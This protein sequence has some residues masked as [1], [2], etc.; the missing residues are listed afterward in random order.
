MSL[1]VVLNTKNASQTLA[2]TLKSIEKIADE[3]IVVDM[4]SDDDTVAIAKKFGAD[5]IPYKKNPGYVE[6]ARN[7]AV[8]KAKSDWILVLDAD[9]VVPQLLADEIKDLTQHES[10]VNCYYVARKNLIFGQWFQHT[11]WWPDYQPRL[12]R[13]GKVTWSTT[14]HRLPGVVG[15]VKHLPAD[16]DWALSHNNYPTVEGFL[17]RLNRYTSVTARE[18]LKQEPVPPP[19]TSL[20]AFWQEFLSRCFAHEGLADTHRGVSLSLLQAMYEAV[21]VLKQAELDEFAHFNQTEHELLMELEKWPGQLHYW[22]A[23]WHVHHEKGP[24]QWWWR[25]RRKL[26][27]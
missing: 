8:S 21:V 16:P 2:A 17:K 24:R 18:L 11:G 25:L 13:K 23:D 4:M 7:F 15:P 26:R 12:F 3:I 5:V 1:S 9:E 6:P 27:V 22:L 14:I 20:Q 19:I 10:D